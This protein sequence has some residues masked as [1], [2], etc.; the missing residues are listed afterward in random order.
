MCSL[1][2][3]LGAPCLLPRPSISL[4]ACQSLIPC[5][6]SVI[7]AL[8][9]A[10]GPWQISLFL[11]LS[12]RSLASP[13]QASLPLQIASTR[14]HAALRHRTLPAAAPLRAQSQPLASSPPPRATPGDPSVA[15]LP[16]PSPT[17]LP[18]AGNPFPAQ[19]SPAQ[20]PSRPS[21]TDFTRPGVSACSGGGEERGQRG[22]EAGSAGHGGRRQG[23]HAG[24][25]GSRVGAGLTPR[26][27]ATR[28]SR[29][30]ASA[31][32]L[33]LGEQPSLS[34]AGCIS[35]GQA[36]SLAASPSRLLDLGLSL[37]GLSRCALS[38]AQHQDPGPAA[39]RLVEEGE[40]KIRTTSVQV[41][42]LRGTSCVTCLLCVC[43]PAQPSWVVV[44]I[45]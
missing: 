1:L 43:F 3:E 42:P 34:R 27:G 35:L 32:R 40:L 7:G 21:R 44:K 38:D 45:T 20:H 24:V 6:T 26:P 14:A 2:Q 31:P 23:R 13:A 37:V 33:S 12:V 22:E 10:P 15:Q 9:K 29:L 18:P 28:P 4:C 39:E 25:P 11:T 36:L 41:Q 5:L 8:D 30:P 19:P 17:Q 16:S